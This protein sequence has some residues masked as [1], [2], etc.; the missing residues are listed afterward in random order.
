MEITCWVD[1][2]SHKFTGD[3]YLGNFDQAFER[4]KHLKQQFMTITDKGALLNL[5]RQL[6]KI[7]NLKLEINWIGFKKDGINDFNSKIHFEVQLYDL[8]YTI[9]PQEG[10]K[11]NCMTLLYHQTLDYKVIQNIVSGYVKMMIEDIK[12]K[13]RKK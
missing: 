12:S 10:T 2:Q 13:V 3:N 8:K 11:N 9:V 1:N 5:D 7:K 4:V 6:D